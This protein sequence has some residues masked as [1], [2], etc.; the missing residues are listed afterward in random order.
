VVETQTEL[1]CRN[2]PDTTLTFVN[3]AYCRHF[4]RTREQLIGRKFLELIPAQFHAAVVEHIQSVVNS[5]GS[6]TSE[7]EHQ[8]VNA[9]GSLGWQHWINRVIRDASGCLVEIQGS[10]RDVTERKRAEDELLQLSA[11]LLSL[12]DEERRRIARQLH[13]VTAQNLFAITINLGS[14]ARKELP[15]NLKD[16]LTESQALCEQALQ[17]IRTLSYLLHPPMLDQAGLVAALQWYIDG[18]SKRSSIEVN[19]VVTQEITRLRR[20]METD[21]FR[22]VQ[23]SLV[24][25]HRH[26]GSETATVRLG[27]QA[28]LLIL[29]IEDQGRGIPKAVRPE[30]EEES[31]GVG[32]LGMRHRMRQLGGRLEVESTAGE[33]TTVRAIV[34][35]LVERRLRV[36]AGSSGN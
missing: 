36:R 27:Q 15:A 5:P 1:I 21:L 12:Q 24:N 25:I 2:L 22:V 11:Q 28:D 13:D 19:L 18:F 14:L 30:S 34:P 3:D 16:S 35:L 23:E 20:D 29:Q 32:I 4:G 17:E 31:L 10:G 26:S 6:E 33:G 7:Q 9:D 8:V